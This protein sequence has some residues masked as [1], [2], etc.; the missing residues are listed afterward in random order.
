MA[1]TWEYSALDAKL[2]ELNATIAALKLQEE[3]LA[4]D[5]N[6]SLDTIWML[7]AGILVFFM[8][9]GFSLLETGCVR[10]KNTQ[11]ILTKKSDCGDLWFPCLVLCWISNCNW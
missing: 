6:E 10:Q 11:N 4:A 7:L 8:H 5:H 1:P 9:A 2:E 3:T